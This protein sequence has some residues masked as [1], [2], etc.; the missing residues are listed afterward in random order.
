MPEAFLDTSCHPSSFLL[1]GFVEEHDSLPLRSHYILILNL[2][3]LQTLLFILDGSAL[4]LSFVGR[5]AGTG[6]VYLLQPTSFV[7]IV[8]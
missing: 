6:D 7:I 8:L 1:H 4:V 2:V 5:S 3:F